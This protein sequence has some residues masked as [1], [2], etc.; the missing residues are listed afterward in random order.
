MELYK[1]GRQ[2]EFKQQ[3]RLES[4]LPNNSGFCLTIECLNVFPEAHSSSIQH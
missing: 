3:R 1:A 2:I 4:I